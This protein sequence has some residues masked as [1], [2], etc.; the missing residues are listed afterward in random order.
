MADDSTRIPGCHDVCG[1]IFDHNAACADRAIVANTDARTNNTAA[2]NPHIIPNINFSSKVAARK[3]DFGI[4]GMKSSV[5]LHV[6]AAQ[7]IFANVN[8]IAVEN[9][10]AKIHVQSVSRINIAAVVA[11]KRRLDFNFG[12]DCTE[13]FGKDF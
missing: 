13:Q 12:A 6:G 5:N 10:A 4:G 7:Q 3:S 11:V 2:A 1:N 9:H 8:S